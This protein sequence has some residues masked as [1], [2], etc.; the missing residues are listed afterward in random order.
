[1]GI[2]GAA[3]GQHFEVIALAAQQNQRR[4]VART[5]DCAG[6]LDRYDGSVVHVD[7]VCSSKKLAAGTGSS[8]TNAAA[9]TLV[10]APPPRLTMAT[11]RRRPN[12]FPGPGRAAGDGGRKGGRKPPYA[13]R[14][15]RGVG[16]IVA[17]R[18]PLE[19]EGRCRS[20]RRR[21]HRRAGGAPPLGESC[22]N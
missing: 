13:R 4:S 9:F 22:R 6:L 20:D 1:P 12:V 14:V 18:P 17:R 10:R 3:A 11:S 2:T 15:G 16:P 5:Y 21:S 7:G 8:A 19:G